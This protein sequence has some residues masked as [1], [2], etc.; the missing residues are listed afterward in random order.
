MIGIF[1][2]GYGGLTILNHI[3]Q[4]LPQYP[5]IYLG[6]NARAPYGTRSF[7]TI[8]EYTLQA[9]RFLHQQGCNLIIL[10][11]NTASAKALRT[12]Q[13][14]DIDSESLRVL[15]VIR[16][17]AETAPTYTHTQHI[18]VL[19]TLGTVTSQSYVIELQKQNPKL[20]IT[21][22]PCPMWVP[23]IEAGEHLNDGANYFVDK[24]LTQLLHKDP[25]IDT[26]IL[27]CTHYPLILPKIQEFFLRTNRQQPHIISQGEIVANSLKD[28]LHRHLDIANKAL[29]IPEKYIGEF[30]ASKLHNCIFL[31]TESANKF[32]ESASIFLSENVQALHIEL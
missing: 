5:Y 19:A 24:Y 14:R 30:K 2:S 6:D 22:Q 15:G 20:Q 12:I 17:T 26:L 16:P 11:C 27:G 3:R 9:V 31:T 23:L 13:Q 1:D 7:D 21:Q 8:Y 28:Y 32:S 29:F 4:L 10:A 25:L 18:G